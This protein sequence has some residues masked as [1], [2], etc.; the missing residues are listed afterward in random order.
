MIEKWLDCSTLDSQ[1]CLILGLGH[2]GHGGYIHMLISADL[3]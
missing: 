2:P 1:F 3:L